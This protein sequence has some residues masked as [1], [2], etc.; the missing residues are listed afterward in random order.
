MGQWA[1]IDTA[2]ALELLSPAFKH[3]HV[4]E[5]AV[6]T[7]E[8]QAD[9]DELLS[10]LLPLV[11]VGAAAL[12]LAR[13]VTWAR[14][15]NLWRAAVWCPGPPASACRASHVWVADTPNQVCRPR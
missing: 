5:F 2:D 1:A 9:A 7:L 15:Q 12:A 10:Y 4:R 11:Q 14:G 3:Q 13:C 8:K 6:A